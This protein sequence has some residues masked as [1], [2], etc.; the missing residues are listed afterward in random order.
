ME[1]NHI[2]SVSVSIGG[3]SCAACVR[4]VENGLRELEGVEDAAVNFASERATVVFDDEAVSLDTIRDQVREL[5]YEVRGV[6][7]DTPGGE[8]E[9]TI[10][11]GGMSC[12]ACVRR[13]ENTL[14]S[15]PGVA[16][17]AV[18]F[19]ANTATVRYDPSTASLESFGAALEDAGYSFIGVHEE[20]TADR[21]REARQQE[22]RRLTREFILSAVL[23]A[24]IMIGSMQHMFP[25]LRD[26]PHGLMHVVLFVLTTV[27]LTVSGRR[28]FSGAWSAAKHG[29]SD[30]NT[31]IAIGTF[32]AW[33]YSTVATFHPQFFTSSGMEAAVYFDTAAMITTLILMGRLLEARARSQTSDAIRKLMGL[34]AKTARVIRDGKETDVPV[35]LVS[36]DDLVVVRP[37]EKIPVDGTIEEGRS[38]VDESMLTGEPI[39]VDKSVGD[40]VIG[41]TINKTG[42]FTFRAKRV[43]GDTAL[44]QIIR[45]VEKA[46]GSKAPVQRLADKVA[47]IFVP[48]VIGAA[49]VTFIV[50]YFFGPAP[51]LTYAMLNFVAVLIVACPCSMGLATPTAIMVGTGKGAELG[52]LIKDAQSL[53]QAHRID[54]VVFDK[55]GTLTRGKPQVTDIRTVEGFD[56]NALLAMVA[57]VEK[58][59]EHP[60]GEAVVQLAESRNIT[61]A[62]PEEFNA[63]SGFGVEARLNGTSVLLGNGRLM[64]ERGVSAGTLAKDAEK[65]LSDGK[66][67]IFAAENGELKG[68]LAMADTLKE[69]SAEAVEMMKKMGLEVIMITG[70]QRRTA[71]AVARQAA[72]D[73]VLAEV[74]PGDKAAEIK[75]LQEEGRIVAMVGDG[76][77]DAPA[78]AQADIGIAIGA[79]TDVAVEASN[80]TLVKDDLRSVVTAIN[81]SHRTM[82]TIKQNLFWAFIYNSLGIPIAA[83]VL[84]PFSGILL[85]PVFAAVAMAFSSVSVVSNSL[86]LKR[87]RS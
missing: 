58:A 55:T 9:V 8:K 14:G 72:I 71:E 39:P 74:L 5:G 41:A 85:K 29:T 27:V 77:N 6:Q 59:S 33:A 53:E 13:V 24:F 26:V 28:F 63:I 11:V 31:L 45:L 16:E 37:G 75:R 76:I 35:S 49:V 79:G 2:R 18:N 87:F 68:L 32:S 46:Q 7:D 66:T 54:T 82:R 15:L 40:E 4:R 10:N 51:A 23:T 70:D 81:L 61:L 60:L 69:H 50:W 83:G 42:S 73:R 17:A 44:S 25:V 48:V 3:M 65:L 38:S 36:K 20:A 78:L 12:A 47:S 57:S 19:A 62:R 84:F 30:M 34:A 67:V 86:R 22:T 52:I 21:E 80:I 1:Q 64:S 43:G 56:E